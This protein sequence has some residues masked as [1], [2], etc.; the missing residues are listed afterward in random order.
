M[1]EGSGTPLIVETG[2]MSGRAVLFVPP[3]TAIKLCEGVNHGRHNDFDTDDRSDFVFN[4]LTK[5][6]NMRTIEDAVDDLVVTMVSDGALLL[7]REKVREALELD[8]HIPD[9]DEVQLIVSGDDDG[10]IP[11]W[12]RKKFHH[13][14]DYIVSEY[15]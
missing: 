5:E 15:C 4:H 8:G 10:E 2:G 3:I 12:L 11:E 7:S 14:E 9:A 6:I 1:A 13:L